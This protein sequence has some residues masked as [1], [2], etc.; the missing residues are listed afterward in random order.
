MQEG[1]SVT[2]P[3]P[4]GL[5]WVL[6]D[7]P[8]QIEALI[9][10]R[11]NAEW[12]RINW[13]RAAAVDGSWYDQAKADA[14]V[15]MWPSLFKLTTNRFAGR[16]FHLSWWQEIIVRMMIG[17]KKPIEETDPATG[18]LA[19]YHVR[20]FRELMLWVPRKNGKSEFLA[21]LSLLFWWLDGLRGGEGYVFARDEEQAAIALNKMK[22]MVKLLP[23]KEAGQFNIYDKSI[24]CPALATSFMVLT[25]AE[26]GK[27][28]KAPY[29]RFGDEMHEWKTTKIEDD[30][31]QGTGVYLQPVGLKASTAGLK[32]NDVGVGQFEF[33]RA[34]LAGE[35]DDP[36]VLAVIFAAGEDDDPFDEA[37]WAKA[38]P[39]LRVSVTLDA[40]KIEAAK[41]RQTPTAEAHF[42]AYH[43]NQWVENGQRW[44]RPA[45]WDA[46]APDKQAWRTRREAMQGRKC[47]IGFDLADKRDFNALVFLFEP[48]SPDEPWQSWGRYWVPEGTMI[49][50][51]KLERQRLEEFARKGALNLSQGNVNDQRNLI[52]LI[53]EAMT[54]F[55]V[56]AIA[57]DRFQAGMVVTEL[58]HAGVDGDLLIEV[59][60][61]HRSMG[62]PSRKFE[63][64]VY[65]GKF[66]HGGDPVLR[67]HAINTVCRYDENLN[68][69]P[70]KAKSGE[71]IDG[72]IAAICGLAA[73]MGQ[74]DNSSIY[75]TRGPL[76]LG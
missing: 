50:R 67:W 17:W 73:W 46:C 69:M 15:K 55:D 54:E 28:G 75:E 57:F 41:A 10:G 26:A 4:G 48:E 60:M 45:V 72:V 70:G 49:E 3:E 38:N 51:D 39:N 35:I 12:V 37:V 14:V 74:E 18:K 29:V 23:Q 40:L 44:I 1:D 34:V 16:P 71:K 31:R 63:E 2:T 11:E 30:L 25:G 19:T 9:A 22:D 21:A 59:A 65:G 7:L 52:K 62:A 6:V 68:I 13:S 66:D 27:H 42:R 36:T 20:I 8:E 5:P 47:W 43:L 33:T 24:Y 53:S 76:V 64:L 56:Q 32:S 58:Q 61:G